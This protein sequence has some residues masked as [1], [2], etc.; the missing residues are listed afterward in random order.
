MT[1]AK[2]MILMLAIYIDKGKSG[3]SLQMITIY[4]D[5]RKSDCSFI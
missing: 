4:A 2:Y 1:E 5:E 3:D